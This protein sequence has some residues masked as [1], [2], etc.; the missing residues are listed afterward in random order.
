MDYVKGIFKNRPNRFI[1][2]VE[3]KGNIEFAHVPNMLSFGSNLLIIRIGKQN[4][5][6]VLLKIKEFWFLSIHSKPIA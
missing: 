5:H 3:V 6:F 4:F 1:A 2:E